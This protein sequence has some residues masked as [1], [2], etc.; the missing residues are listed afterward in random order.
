MKMF[1][2]LHVGTSYR[3]VTADETKHAQEVYSRYVAYWNENGCDKKRM[4]SLAQFLLEDVDFDR[5]DSFI[6]EKG[7]LVKTQDGQIG[8]TTGWSRIGF[9]KPVFA[10]RVKTASGEDTYAADTLKDANIPPEVLE[11]VKSTLQEKVH[12]KVDEA[13][14]GEQ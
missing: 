12:D 7:R 2:L 13:F 3:H 11:Y 6:W 1:E 5:L 10:V 8:I 4:R 14:R 9:D